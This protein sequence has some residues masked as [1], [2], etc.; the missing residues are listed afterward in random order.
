MKYSYF[1]LMSIFLPVFLGAMEFNHN[2]NS[3]MVFNFQNNMKTT[4]KIYA[5]IQDSCTKKCSLKKDN[6]MVP[7]DPHGI[8]DQLRKNKPKKYNHA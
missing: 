1:F 3:I 6:K 5:C 4:P 7:L 8:E 2:K